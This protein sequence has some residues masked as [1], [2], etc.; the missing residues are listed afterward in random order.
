MK[1]RVRKARIADVKG[2]HALLTKYGKENQLLSR[3]LSELYDQL[4]DFFVCEDEEAQYKLLGM[5]AMH[6]CWEDIAEIRSLAVWPEYQGKGIGSKLV[7]AC[8]SEA[9]T[10][11]IY[12]IFVL[13]YKPSFFERIGFEGIDKA[14][15]PHKVWADCLKCPKFPDCDEVALLLSL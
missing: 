14:E 10:I 3:S 1:I 6:I 2:I 5:C 7:D 13:T 9:V 8:L 15:L 11:G 12:K 4:R